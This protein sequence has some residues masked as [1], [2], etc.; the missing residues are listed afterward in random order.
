MAR[1]PRSPLAIWPGWPVSRPVWSAK[2]IDGDQR[3]WLDVRRA[4]TV[5]VLDYR[6]APYLRFSPSGID[7]NQ[8]SAM[9]YLN[10]TPAEV[11]PKGLTAQDAAEVV[12]GERGHA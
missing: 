6:G 1:W 7:V 11:P 8:N 3:M 5:V 4:G 2:V 12:G 10:Q 9:Y